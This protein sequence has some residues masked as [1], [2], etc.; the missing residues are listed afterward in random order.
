V[1]RKEEE[2]EMNPALEGMIKILWI[3]AVGWFFIWFVNS[4]RRPR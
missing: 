1:A 2:E 4:F 3:L